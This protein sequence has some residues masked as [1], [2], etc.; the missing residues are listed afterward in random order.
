MLFCIQ[1]FAHVGMLRQT[2]TCA[3]NSYK[4]SMTTISD[5]I[6]M[7]NSLRATH[8]LAPFN[9]GVGGSPASPVLAGPLFCI[10]DHFFAVI[11]CIYIKNYY[12]NVIKRMRMAV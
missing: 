3:C 1:S 7:P 2:G 10:V 4:V 6:C 9:R 11:Y 8:A 5:L 12:I